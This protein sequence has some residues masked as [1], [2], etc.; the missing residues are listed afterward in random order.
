MD[1]ENILKIFHRFSGID[2]TLS[3]DSF[4]DTAFAEV[5]IRLKTQKGT[6]EQTAVTEYLA[7]ALA[8]YKY[9]LTLALNQPNSMRM[10]DLT[11]TQNK[12]DQLKYSE[13]IKND[14]LIAASQYLVDQSF[15]FCS[16]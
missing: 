16:I 5:S 11:I 13:A 3:Y 12:S 6:T 9:S 14:A 7:A 8:L 15:Y 10:L 2:D 4:I 1:K